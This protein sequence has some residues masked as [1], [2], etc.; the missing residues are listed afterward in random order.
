ML[1]QALLVT[2]L[3]ATPLHFARK[4]KDAEV[5]LKLPASVAHAPVLH[6]RL[7]RGEV[8][9][10]TK[11]VADAA[12]GRRDEPKAFRELGA[13]EDQIDYALTLETPRLMG[14]R[15]E[16]YVDT[17][18]AHPNHPSGGIVFDK[19]TNTRVR[20]LDLLRP[21]ADIKTLDRALCDAARAAKRERADGDW[22]EKEDTNFSCPTW[23]GLYLN[24]KLLQGGDPV[25]F[26]LAPGT[27]KDR[28]GGLI[29]VYSP[30]ELGAYVE[31]GYDLVLPLA[32][33]RDALKPEYAGE[34]A[35]SPK[36]LP[37]ES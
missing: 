5:S 37:K 21:G 24:G 16:E 6:D 26:T 15:R 34:F 36:P 1:L 32:V 12:S 17:H 4:T 2:L 25:Q 10:L 35:G 28:A 18:G 13:W 23:R 29:F 7:Y 9:G 3:A 22:N 31:G 19:A 14:L 27:V 30:Y 8:K 33:L 20:A 11:F